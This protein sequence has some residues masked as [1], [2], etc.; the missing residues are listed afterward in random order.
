MWFVVFILVYGIILNIINPNVTHM[1]DRYQGILGNP[2]GLG[3]YVLLFTLGFYLINN[4]FTDCFST[5]ERIFIYG[6]NFYNLYL[7]G[8]RTALIAVLLF[9]FIAKFYKANR[10]LGLIVFMVLIFSI[11]FISDNID[12]I[13]LSLGLEKYF[14]IETIDTGSGRIVAWQFAW[15]NL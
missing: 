11:Q 1:L 5:N 14:R 4:L 15:K 9:L 2:N 12:T 7:C 8:A 3:V 13:I 10:F 6:I